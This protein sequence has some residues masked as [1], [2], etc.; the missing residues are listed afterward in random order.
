LL[1]ALLVPAAALALLA[2]TADAGEGAS[3]A[4]LALA[5]AQGAAVQA[6]GGVLVTPEKLRELEAMARPESP[7]EDDSMELALEKEEQWREQQSAPARRVAKGAPTG[8]A[9]GTPSPALEARGDKA[10][11][12]AAAQTPAA[13]TSWQAIQ[14]PGDIAADTGIAVSHTVVLVT[15]RSTIAYYDKS[16]RSLGQVS[17]PAFFSPLGLGSQKIDTYFDTRSIYDAYRN[18]FWVAALAW[19]SESYDFTKKPEEQDP[20]VLKKRRNRCVMAVSKTG[21]PRDGWYLYAWNSTPGDGQP[22]L[23]GFQAGDS[24]DY[25]LLGVDSFGIY[26]SNI[27]ANVVPGVSHRT[28]QVTFFPAAKLAAGQFASGWMFYDLK[29]PD[30]TPVSLIQPVVHHGASPRTYFVTRYGPNKVGVW[31]LTGHLTPSQQLVVGSVSLT[32]FTYP[33]DAPQYGYNEKIQLTNLGNEPLK[34]VFRSSR[35]YVTFHDAANFFGD[36]VTTACRFAR[37]NV[38]SFPAVL[39]EVDRYFGGRS[40]VYDAPQMRVFYGFPAVE[41]NKD[42][43]AILVYGRSS[44]WFYPEVSFSSYPLAGPDI[45][46]SRQLSKGQDRFVWPKLDPL[47]LY[48]LNA[49][50]VDPF[51]DTAVWIAAPATIWRSVAAQGNFAVKV[52]K[53]LGS[54]WA[55]L[56]PDAVPTVFAGAVPAGGSFKVSVVV[57]NQGDGSCVASKMAVY[58][59]NSS[60]VAKLAGYLTTAALGSGKTATVSGLLPRGTNPKG[61]YRVKVIVDGL[62]T[63]TEYSGAN[64]TA[65]SLSSIYLQ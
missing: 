15:T 5:D 25:P 29:N 46:P 26:Q 57:R 31:G 64:N 12:H 28:A 23:N 27:V 34:A 3:D 16:G 56:V 37:L 21:D 52:G 7:T 9:E 61:Y 43:D 60:N 10:A 47:P 65:T 63:V 54:R 55:D 38:A 33:L 36:G 19:N 42:G 50:T 6:E 22:G 20:A 13:V 45:L 39:K 11:I 30:N 4:V 17:T 14:A 40:D 51:D 2:F 8:G 32:A 58:L 44:L 53:V 41:A 49:A 59:A 1:G 35:L 18:R 62:N 48:D 24:A